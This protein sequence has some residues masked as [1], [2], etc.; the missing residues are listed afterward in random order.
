[1]KSLICTKAIMVFVLMLTASTT[2]AAPFCVVRSYGK[3]CYYYDWSS[4]QRA[5]GN[6]GACIINQKEVKAPVGSAPF[7]IVASYGAMCLLL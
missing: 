3:E 4:C 2:F 5:A 6:Q 7:C 1:M